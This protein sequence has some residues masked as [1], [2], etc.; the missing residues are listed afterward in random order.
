MMNSQKPKSEP[1]DPEQIDAPFPRDNGGIPILED[2]VEPLSPDDI[3]LVDSFDEASPDGSPARMPDGTELRER[4]HRLLA[5]PGGGMLDEL[6]R[7]AAGS[8]TGRILERLEPEIRKEV[9]NALRC[10]F[11]EL[12]GRDRPGGEAES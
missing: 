9:E 1:L 12:L 10:G 2:I 3:D 8:A 6:I 4:L 5:D 11:H 7:D